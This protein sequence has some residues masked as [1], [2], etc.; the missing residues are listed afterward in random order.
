[1]N[2]FKSLEYKT[3]L[4]VINALE[5]LLLSDDSALMCGPEIM[6]HEF[7]EG[8]NELRGRTCPWNT[9]A[10]WKVDRLGL[11]GY[12]LIGDGTGENR[13]IGGVEVRVF[14]KSLSSVSHM[15]QQEVTAITLYQVLYPDAYGILVRFAS[16]Q[17]SDWKTDFQEIERIQ[18]H[19]KKMRSK[20]ERPGAQLKLL[21]TRVTQ[22][23]HIVHK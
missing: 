19:E 2:N 18:Y 13:S 23:L 3:T 9:C 10:V 1:M 4:Y 21:N 15:H 16:S 5:T 7:K 14:A 11:I 17:E 12:P 6:G 22:V 8:F 20:D